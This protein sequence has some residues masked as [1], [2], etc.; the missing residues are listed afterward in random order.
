MRE[1]EKWKQSRS[2]VSDSSQPHGPQPTR[3]LHPWD[4]PGKSTGV[5]CHCL[6]RHDAKFKEISQI[7]VQPHT[8]C[9]R[10]QKQSKKVWECECTQRR[11]PGTSQVVQWLRLCT[12]GF[13][14]GGIQLNP[15]PKNRERGALQSDV[16]F[17]GDLGQ[18]TVPFLSLGKVEH[19]SAFRS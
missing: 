6:L 14:G 3:L 15:R 13:H 4:F 17:L 9:G 8:E 2:V 1:S 18:V 7:A 16:N 5:G 19:S 10:R 12:L 11:A